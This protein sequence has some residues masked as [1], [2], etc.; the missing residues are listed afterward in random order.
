MLFPTRVFL[1]FFVLV[2]SAYWAL[3]PRRRAQ[4]ALLLAASWYFYGYWDERFLILI[5]I[6]TVVD[7]LCGLGFDRYR[8]RALAMRLLMGVS[9]LVNLGALAFFK[10]WNFFAD[11]AAEL[12]GRLGLGAPDWTLQIVLPVGISFYTFQTLSYS[13]DRY[14]GAIPTERDLI[15][16][17]FFVSFFPQLVAGPIVRASEFLPQTRSTR[18]F[19]WEDQAGG[20]RLALWGLFKKTVVADNLAPAVDTVFGAESEVGYLARLIAVYAFAIQIY[21]DFSGYTD[22]A[23]GTAR[24]LGFEFP[25]NFLRPYFS[26]DPSTFWRRWHVSLS[27][28]LRDYLYIGLGGNRRGPRR[29]YVN[30]M[31]TMALG[32]LWH[33]AAW[34]FVLWGVYQGAL[35][36]VHRLWREKRGPAAELAPPLALLQGVLFFQFVCLGWLF[37]RAQSFEQIATFLTPTSAGLLAGLTLSDVV[38]GGLVLGGLGALV[39]LVWDAC[40]ARASDPETPLERAPLVVQLGACTALYL[41]ISFAGRFLGNEFI[42]FQF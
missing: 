34:N 37:F 32:G 22:I 31:A 30:L 27:S 14:R 19:R 15:D 21:C 24:M 9:L 8:G 6:S 4:N 36:V 26:R 25:F 23:R 20:L 16:F 41:A 11:S 29:T 28:W 2:W 10:Y 17:A 33:G 35:L 38:A 13:I 1:L 3:Q 42:Y 12:C 18:T 40:A 39:V 5:G 7:W